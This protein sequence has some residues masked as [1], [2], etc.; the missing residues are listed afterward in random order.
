MSKDH[1]KVL[2][3]SK[4]IQLRLLRKSMVQPDHYDVIAFVDI[5]VAPFVGQKKPK[6]SKFELKFKPKGSII[7]TIRIYVPLI[8]D[9]D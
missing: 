9:D 5:D 7:A 3:K 6:V 1:D 8:S 2:Y 4:V